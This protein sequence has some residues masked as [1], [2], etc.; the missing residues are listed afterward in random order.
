MMV[1]YKAY[2]TSIQKYH[3]IYWV[4]PWKYN[5]I[6]KLHLIGVPESGCNRAIHSYIICYV[7]FDHYDDIN[8]V[9]HIQA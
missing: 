3:L 2:N 7:L 9:S 4:W 6:S 8:V 1:Q 5:I